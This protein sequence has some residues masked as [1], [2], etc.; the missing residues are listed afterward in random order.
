MDN[1]NTKTLYRKIKK[2]K[3]VDT[4]YIAGLI[5]GE[6]TIT[7]SR[8]NWWRQRCLTVVI[9]NNEYKILKWTLGTIGTGIITKK[10]TYKKEHSPSFAYKIHNQQALSLLEKITPYMQ[11]YKKERAKLVLKNYTKLTPRN[12]KYSKDI[13]NKR[14]KFIETFFKMK[15]KVF[16]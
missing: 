8:K 16:E 3:P 5:D 1:K 11:S 2:L 13:L 14:E 15:P 4:S 7:L 9:S 12:G 10:R 6:G